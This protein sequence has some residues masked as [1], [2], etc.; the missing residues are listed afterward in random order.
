[1]ELRKRNRR[2]A[3]ATAYLVLLSLAML[4]LGGCLT[5]LAAPDA[6]AQPLA[7]DFRLAT[8]HGDDVSLEDFRDQWVLLNFW[9]TWCAPCIEEMPLPAS[10]G[11][12]GHAAADRDRR[13]H[14]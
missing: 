8:L 9:A 6:E 13:E 3:S 2:G 4:W 14:A 10:A 12:G 1:M 11:P 7:P 5:P